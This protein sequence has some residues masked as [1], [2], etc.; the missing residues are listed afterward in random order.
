MSLYRDYALLYLHTSVSAAENPTLWTGTAALVVCNMYMEGLRNIM[1][2][3]SQDGQCF[4]LDS[5]SA[6][7]THCLLCVKNG[8][9]GH[10]SSEIT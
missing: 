8:G 6:S 1:Y 5:N 7:S 4:S 9:F 2:V 10:E 3:R